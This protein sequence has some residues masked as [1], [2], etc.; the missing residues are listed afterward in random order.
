[1]IDSLSPYQAYGVVS[2]P[3]SP[4]S[5]GADDWWHGRALLSAPVGSDWPLPLP[6]AGP[7]GL[8]PLLVERQFRTPLQ[9]ASPDG[10]HDPWPKNGSSDLLTGYGLVAGSSNAAKP[11]NELYVISGSDAS[12]D[13]LADRLGRQGSRVLRLDPSAGLRDCVQQLDAEVEP[14]SLSRLHLINHGAPDQLVIGS[15]VRGGCASEELH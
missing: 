14:G 6:I 12:L 3:S 11:E 2:A 5:P 7:E 15:T 9:V 10:L 1:M 4:A 13:D 8:Q